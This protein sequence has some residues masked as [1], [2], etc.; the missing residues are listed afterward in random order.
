MRSSLTLVV[1][2]VFLF[3]I[4]EMSATSWRAW[5]YQQRKA[6]LGT[7]INAWMVAFYG[8]FARIFLRRRVLHIATASDT[9][10]FHSM[11]Q[12]INSVK[13]FETGPYQLTAYD[14]GLT[15][16]D[17]VRFAKVHPDVAL[18]RFPFEQYPSHFDI[19]QG[20]G[21]YAWKPVIVHEVYRTLRDGDFF[22]WLDAGNFVRRRMWVIRAALYFSGFYTRL[23]TGTIGEWTH[24]ETFRRLGMEVARHYR[25]ICGCLV[26]VRKDAR[27]DKLVQEWRDGAVD[28][29]IIAPEGSSRKNHRQD[30]SVVSLLYYR[31]YSFRGHPPRLSRLEHELLIHQD[32]G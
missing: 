25:M 12:L 3:E 9:T 32:I 31:H 16:S 21:E 5:A 29:G 20:A 23:T 30:Q 11:L 28:K 7:A 26:A 1:S 2:C 6:L 15:E 13:I 4:T 8:F 24:E 19:S 22:L 18:V 27:N 14:L 17:R 10:H